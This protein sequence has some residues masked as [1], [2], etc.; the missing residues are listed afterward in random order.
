MQAGPWR[1]AGPLDKGGKPHAGREAQGAEV[2]GAHEG[3]NMSP[4]SGKE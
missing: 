4:E 1:D 2:E 3:L